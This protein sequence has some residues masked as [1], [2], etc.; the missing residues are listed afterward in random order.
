MIAVGPG[1]AVSRAA[2]RYGE[3]VSHVDFDEI[4]AD[5]TAEEAAEHA[6]AR[7]SLY[8]R[9]RHGPVLRAVAKADRAGMR[10]IRQQARSRRATRVVK[11][12]SKLGEHGGLWLV[13][14]ATGAVLDRDRRSDWQVATAGVAVAYL[15]NTSLKQVARRPRPDFPD[16][17]PLVSTPGPLSF[18]SSHA[19][20]SA[21]AYAGFAPLLPAGP[22]GVAAATMAIS[23]VHLGVHYPSDI[24]VGAVLGTLTA[25]GLRRVLRDR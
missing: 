20:S 6:A 7:R 21:A 24:A 25:H 12:Y 19:S 2:A 1:N 10:F 9:L 3:A 17:P 23:R 18:P 8:A 11:T 13:V 16:L 5:W 4:A 22:L 14:G 15:F